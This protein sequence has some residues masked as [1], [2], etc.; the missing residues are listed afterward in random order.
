MD[1]VNQ[2]DLYW[3]IGFFAAG[4]MMASLAV[5]MLY[6]SARLKCVEKVYSLVLLR[7]VFFAMGGVSFG[8]LYVIASMIGSIYQQGIS[9]PFSSAIALAIGFVSQ[10]GVH[11]FF[12]KD[13]FDKGL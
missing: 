5:C 2:S 12:S 8:A 7:V 4:F 1:F 9:L 6:L 3:F 10:F 13:A 11:Y